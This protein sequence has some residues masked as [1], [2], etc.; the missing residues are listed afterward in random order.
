MHNW[1][2]LGIRYT[3]MR[4]VWSTNVIKSMITNWANE[5][6][7]NKMNIYDTGFP[8]EDA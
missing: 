6:L 2:G 1:S 5:K 4:Y 7:E 3:L 8:K